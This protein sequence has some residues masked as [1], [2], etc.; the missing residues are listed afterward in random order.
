MGTQPA[1]NS[2]T[3]LI[4]SYYPDKEPEI[5]IV[6]QDS[7]TEACLRNEAEKAKGVVR[8]LYE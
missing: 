1:C 8:G 6:C 5:F 3:S 7:K 4:I 2:T